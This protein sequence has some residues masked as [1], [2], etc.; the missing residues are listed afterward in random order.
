[1]VSWVRLF[2]LVA[3]VEGLGGFL[4]AVGHMFYPEERIANLGAVALYATLVVVAWGLYAHRRWAAL[5]FTVAHCWMAVLAGWSAVALPMGMSPRGI[6]LRVMLVLIGLLYLLPAVVTVQYW[7]M[8]T[9]RRPVSVDDRVG[10]VSA[11]PTVG[12]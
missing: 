4:A 1:M 10:G 2:A 7:R 5:F 6:S 9:W 3:L 11:P 8:L 12:G